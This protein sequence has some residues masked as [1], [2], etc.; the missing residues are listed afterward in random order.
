MKSLALVLLLLSAP[1]ALADEMEERRAA[2]T[3]YVDNPVQQKMLDEMLSAEAMVTQMRATLPP[4]VSDAL[5]PEQIQTMARIASEELAD[6]RPAMQTA[7]IEAAAQTFTTAEL[8]ALD[9]FY[10]SPEGASVMGKMQPF[11][12]TFYTGLGGDM[13]AAQMRIIRRVNEAMKP[14]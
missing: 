12:Q 7:M 1:A 5:Q 6:L 8:E 13:Q 2:A 14:Q 3:A 4:N 9:A 11:M 10:S